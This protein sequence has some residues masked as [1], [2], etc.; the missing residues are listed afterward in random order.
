MS[1]LK[2]AAPGKNPAATLVDFLFDEIGNE[3]ADELA[4]AENLIAAAELYPEVGKLMCGYVEQLTDVISERLKLISPSAKPDQRWKV[5]Y[6]LVSL[7]FCDTSMGSLGLSPKFAKASR[8]CALL[9]GQGL[10]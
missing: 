3:S 5:A 2:A 4:V 6:G 7:L 8:D 10:K 9:L 1:S